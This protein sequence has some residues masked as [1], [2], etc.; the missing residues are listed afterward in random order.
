[1]K[2]RFVVVPPAVVAP[3][4][5]TILAIVKSA[6]QSWWIL[7]AIPFIWLGSHCAAP[8]FNL[9]DAFFAYMSMI[10]G[11]IIA[12]F[13]KPV[14]LAILAGVVSG[15]YISAIEMCMRMRPPPDA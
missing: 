3:V 14:G 6:D 13:F 9:A 15:Y 2:D 1:M 11:I 10:I 7:S 12:A 4:I 8:D 5:L